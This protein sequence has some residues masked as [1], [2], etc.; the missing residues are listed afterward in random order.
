MKK[1]ISILSI[2]FLFSACGKEE[3]D[4]TIPRS[5][6]NF[7]VNLQAADNV[8]NGVLGYATFT[9]PRLAGEYIGFAGLLVFTYGIDENGLPAL[10]AFDLCC[11][12]EGR[13]NIRVT[14]GNDGKATCSQCKSVYDLNTGRALSGPSTKH[15][16]AYYIGAEHPYM[17]VFVI[18]N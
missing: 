4:Y 7:R 2:I 18:R 3:L 9:K 6:V 12:H 10:N 5:N 14:P 16:Q 13:Q 8:L 1:I 15:L 17:G 11:P